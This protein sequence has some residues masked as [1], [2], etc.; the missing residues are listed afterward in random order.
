MMI[1]ANDIYQLLLKI[2]ETHNIKLDS[3]KVAEA[4]RQLSY[5]MLMKEIY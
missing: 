1:N 5:L 3:R 2:I 4:W